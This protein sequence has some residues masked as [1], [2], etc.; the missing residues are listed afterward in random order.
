MADVKIIMKGF[1]L[2]WIPGLLNPK[3]PDWASILEYFL[4]GN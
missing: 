4:I 1:R 3:I 2:A